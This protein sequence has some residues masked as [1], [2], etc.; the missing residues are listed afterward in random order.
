MARTAFT[1]K[2]MQVRGKHG[3][4]LYFTGYIGSMKV[5]RI[6]V[7]LGTALSIIPRR[8]I[9]SLGIPLGRL[10]ATQTTIFKFNSSRTH[11]LGKIM[12]RC[13]IDDLKK[14]VTCRMI[15][16]ETS[17]NLLLGRPRIRCKGIFP[18]TLHQAMKYVDERG[19]VRTFIA[20]RNSFKGVENYFTDSV[21]Y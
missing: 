11:P 1:P 10:N 4:H 14:E 8:L 12:L 16:T 7:D 21:L 5:E 3:R 2:D 6:Q 20:Y 15:D 17:Y 9:K 18:S 13:Q 19:E